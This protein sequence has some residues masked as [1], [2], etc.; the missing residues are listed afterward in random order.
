M[1]TLPRPSHNARMPTLA[2][3]HMAM[4]VHQVLRRI[5]HRMASLHSTGLR[6]GGVVCGDAAGLKNGSMD[7]GSTLTW[8]P[9][10][11]LRTDRNVGKPTAGVKCYK[12]FRKEESQ[13]V[14]KSIYT[15]TWRPWLAW[16]LWILW[17][18]AQVRYSRV[19]RLAK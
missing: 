7:P 2:L 17:I 11:H 5:Q 10:N 3:P 6:K 18:H 12:V 13:R 14:S 8:E 9:H 1:L 16:G 19:E 4:K 15:S